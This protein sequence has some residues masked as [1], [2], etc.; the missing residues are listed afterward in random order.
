MQT[1]EAM[2]VE[3]LSRSDALEAAQRDM[4]T[5]RLDTDRQLAEFRARDDEREAELE[6]ERER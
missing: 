1:V 6:R 2:R 5:K 4:E 3:L